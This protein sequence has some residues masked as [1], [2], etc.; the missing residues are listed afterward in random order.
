MVPTSLVSIDFE[1]ENRTTTTSS[2]SSDSCLLILADGT[3]LDDSAW[4]SPTLGF[5]ETRLNTIQFEVN[6]EVDLRGAQLFF[7]QG[8][9][10]RHVPL[11]IPL[12]APATAPEPMVIDDLEGLTFETLEQDDF[13]QWR[14]DIL[15]ARVALNS[16]E[17]GGKRADW[18]SKLIELRVRVYLN[19]SLASPFSDSRFKLSVDGYTVRDSWSDNGIVGDN[20]FFEAS[21]IFQIPEDTTQFEFFI[22]TAN[23]EWQ[24]VSVD[25]GRVS[26]VV[27][28]ADDAI[29]SD[30]DDT[31]V[32]GDAVADDTVENGM[33]TTDATDDLLDG[34]GTS[35]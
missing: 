20:E 27:K 11:Y 8:A 19:A 16:D 17:H 13:D 32:G 28:P 2:L 7:Y 21:I 10:D 15:S 34:E 6:G 22:D 29:E 14:F 4:E 12:D 25:L 3:T 24:T 1:V 31:A 35:G 33:T 23:G 5:Y 26:P 18:E 9:R 30:V